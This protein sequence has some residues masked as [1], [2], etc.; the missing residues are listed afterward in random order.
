MHSRIT[1]LPILSLALALAPLPAQETETQVKTL[2]MAADQAGLERVFSFGR[3]ISDLDAKADPLAQAIEKILPQLGGKGR[4]AAAQALQEISETSEFGNEIYSC[5]QPLLASK[6]PG[7]AATA[8]EMLGRSAFFNRRTYPKIRR[9]LLPLVTSDLT[10]P[11]L[12]IPAAKALWRVGERAERQQARQVLVDFTRASEQKLKILGAL[13]LAEIN[14]GSLGAA[15]GILQEIADEPTPEGRQARL[16]LLV[17]NQRRTFERHMSEGAA[18]EQRPPA[19]TGSGSRLLML[20]EILSLVSKRHMRGED[21]STAYQLQHAAKGLLNALDRHSTYFTPEEFTR[22]YFDLNSDYGGIGAFVDFDQQGVFSI[23]RPIYSGPAFKANLR[24]GD[25]ILEV[26]GWK[27][28][29]QSSD[30]IISRLKGKPGTDVSIKVMRSGWSEP[31]DF[32]I[33]RQQIQVPSVNHELL[34]GKIGYLEIITFGATTS[35]ELGKALL[36]LKQR[37]ARA[38]VLDLRYNTGGYLEIARRIVELFVP[39]EKL[40]VRT[41]GKAGVLE[42]HHTKD[43]ALLPDIPLAVLINNYSASASEITAGALQDHKRAVVVGGRSFGKGSVQDLFILPSDPPEPFIDQNNNRQWDEG[44][45]YTDRNKNGKYD[46]GPRIKLTIGHYF[47]PSGRSVHREYDEKGELR[48]KDWGVTPDRELPITLELVKHR[49]KEAVVYDLLE[50][51]VF[52]KYVEARL[53]EHK[54]LFVRL[55]E[56]DGGSFAEYPDFEKFY[57]SLNTRLPRDDVRRWLRFEIRKQ[58]SDLRGRVFPGN[59][60]LGDP[61]E[62]VQLQ[63]ALDL[64]FK[65]LGEDI[66]KLKAYAPVLKLAEAEKDKAKAK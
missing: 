26:D 58:V 24:S 9:D 1:S 34:P 64:L 33:R 12:R 22:F 45:S 61:Q 39:G 21:F 11:A 28:E 3:R 32:V 36:E 5:L 4:L 49:W 37:G 63:G 13:A 55:A 65:Q 62:D 51:D 66:T 47:L 42:E 52:R 44:E 8:I 6:E 20:E 53:G 18:P 7:V 17:E 35:E 43:R 40:V 31:R 48:N 23:T 30:E 27:T 29:D 50:Q 59:R 15:R 38:L 2:L 19:T 60:A 41:R 54:E 16:Y 25:Q 57:Q 10:E 46:V 56:S 14:A